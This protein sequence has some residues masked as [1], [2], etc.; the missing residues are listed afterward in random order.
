MIVVGDVHGDLRSVVATIQRLGITGQNLIQVGDVGLGFMSKLRDISNLMVIDEIMQE[1]RNMLYMIRGNHDNP[2]FWDIDWTTVYGIKNVVLVKDYSVIEIEN[3]QVFFLGGGI[4]IDRLART[5]GVNYWKDEVVVL[6]EEKIKLCENADTIITHIA[7]TI[8]YPSSLN[9]MVEGYIYNEAKLGRDLKTEL[10]EERKIMDT[11]QDSTSAS[12]W[13]Y[14]HYHRN[15]VE[16]IGD[17]KYVCVDI[18][19]MYDTEKGDYLVKEYIY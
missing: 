18:L 10:E 14:G 12:E 11:I 2:E 7:P 17:I 3:K 4:S 16:I 13:Y 19:Q 6:D 15:N 9:N 1:T 5:E 8:C